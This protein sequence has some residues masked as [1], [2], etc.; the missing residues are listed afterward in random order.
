[1]SDVASISGV[2]SALTQADLQ[3]AIA[4][5]VLRAA[6]AAD[7]QQADLMQELLASAEA[8]SGNDGLDVYA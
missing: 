5:Q 4:L 2:Q 6:R 7:Q 1:M 8:L 3:S